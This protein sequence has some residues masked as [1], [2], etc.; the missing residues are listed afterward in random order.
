MPDVGIDVQLESLISAACV[1]TKAFAALFLQERF[2]RPFASLTEEI[3]QAI[4]DTTKQKVCIAA[5]R[6]W[7]KSSVN[8][9]ANPARNILFGHKKFIVPISSTATKAEM[10]TENLKREL[11]TNQLIAEIFGDVKTSSW[12][13]EQFIAKDTFVLPRGAGQQVRG[14]NYNGARPDLIIIDDLEDSE[15]VRSEE[16]RLK[17]KEWFYG[18]VCNSVDRGRDDW[19]IIFV[20]TILHEDA[21]LANLLKDPSWCTIK[22]QIC[23]ENLKS[24]WPEYMSDEQVR[25]LYEEYKAQGQADVFAREYRNIAISLEDAVFKHT[26]FKYYEPSEILDNHNLVYCTLVDPAKTTSLHSADSAVVTVAVDLD[27]HKIYVHDVTAGKM[28]PDE[29]FDAIFEHVAQH[30][31]R[32]LGV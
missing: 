27:S 17:L 16:Q 18:D 8:L 30:G 25:Q 32:L 22:L 3:F 1:S 15:S 21:L 23:D 6:G 4:D 20:G 29:L 26:F 13:K 10:E 9:I 31:S 14:I 2:Y 12:S 5:P 7:G 11:T 24:N 28:Y 19:K